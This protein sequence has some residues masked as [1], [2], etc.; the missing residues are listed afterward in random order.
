VTTETAGATRLEGLGWGPFWEAHLAGDDAGRVP[1]RVLREEKQLYLVGAAEGELLAAVS[2]RFMNEARVPAEY[3][4]VG[5]WV[6]VSPRWDEGRGTI[7]R[8]LPRRTVL[9]RKEALAT[10]SQ[11]VI[12][13]NLDF[14][15]VVAG[16]DR[17]FNLRRLERYMVTAF[18]SGIEAVIVLNKADLCDRVAEMVAAVAEAVPGAPIHPVSAEDGTGIGELGG[19]LLPGRTV[20]FIGS[21]GV[22][23]STL[24]NRLLGYE[25]QAVHALSGGFEKGMHTT[26][27]REL[28][29]LPGGALVVDN[30]GMK[31]LQV[32]LD[33]DDLFPVFGDVENIMRG[34][35]FRNC[36]HTEE[37][38]CAVKAKLES[39][40]LDRGRYEAYLKLK[41]EARRLAVRRKMKE[42]QMARA[43]LQ[44]RIRK[45]KKKARAD[46]RPAGYR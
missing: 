28:I 31:E 6:T 38:G 23:K 17:E 9:A 36:S 10:T 20:A 33:A 19:Y 7:H 43:L 44:K 12:A 46:W 24:I 11:Q 5:D 42:R 27:V 39:G 32:W 8:V 14:L 34:C 21:S 16:L 3:P 37:P 29:A 40:E 13:A 26:T 1:A 35:R 25:R 18:E 41:G 15:F 45:E 30:P 2:G 4:K 22:G